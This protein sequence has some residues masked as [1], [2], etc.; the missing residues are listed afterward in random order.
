[1]KFFLT[2]PDKQLHFLVGALLASGTAALTAGNVLAVGLAP[3]VVGILKECWDAAINWWELHHGAPAPH[4]VEFLDAVATALPG[5]IL[6]A[7]IYF[8]KA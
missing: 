7:I 6:A 4:S 5:W 3:F 1:M 2:Q 8:W